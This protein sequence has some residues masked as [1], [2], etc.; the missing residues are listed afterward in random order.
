MG[1]SILRSENRIDS[2]DRLS[3]RKHLG[4]PRSSLSTIHAQVRIRI[5]DRFNFSMPHYEDDSR[6]ARVEQPG[7]SGYQNDKQEDGQNQRKKEGP[8][9]HFVQITVHARHHSI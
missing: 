6:S 3:L 7:S 9:P 5:R 8:P 1:A 2:P 4:Q